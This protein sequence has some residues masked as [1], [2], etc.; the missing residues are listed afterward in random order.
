MVDIDA[1]VAE[2]G[3]F[4]KLALGYRA[5]GSDLPFKDGVFDSYVSP[6]V[7]ML[8]DDP[9]KQITEAFRV[10]KSGSRACFTVWGRR[11]NSVS[12]WIKQRA[13]ENLV[14]KGELEASKVQVDP[15]NSNF[16]LGENIQEYKEFMLSTGFSQV[17]YWYQPMNV[18][19]RN[20]KD[21]V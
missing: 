14:A 13:M 17:K 20:G 4:K 12:F 3:E 16:E 18:L 19:Y 6:L 9:K 15:V 11:E 10:L 5:S 21:F 1:K 7:L 2:K 8:I